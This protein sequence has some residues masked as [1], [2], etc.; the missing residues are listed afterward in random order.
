MPTKLQQAL[1]DLDVKTLTIKSNILNIVEN[2]KVEE[3]AD[4]TLLDFIFKGASRLFQDHINGNKK[5]QNEAYAR[6]CIEKL[7]AGIPITAT[8]ESS[9]LTSREKLTCEGLWLV[10]KGDAAR[11]AN[12]QPAKKKEFEREY[13]KLGFESMVIKAATLIGQA[14]GKDQKPIG[15]KITATVENY[16]KEA[17]ERQQG[18]SIDF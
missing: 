15:E 12:V 8:R 9:G 10:W 5:F 6:E 2:L 4:S 11:K 1:L 14:L 13:K 16:V 17:L 18:L 3:V 7:K